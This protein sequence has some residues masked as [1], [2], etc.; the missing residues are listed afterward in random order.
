MKKLVTFGCSITKDNYQDT[1]ADLLAHELGVDLHNHAERGAGADYVS[2]RILTSDIEVDDLVVIMWPSA[3]R[4][5]LWADATTPH[6]LQD[7]VHAS[8]PDGTQPQLVDL[9]GQA[10]LDQGYILNGSVP[11]GYKH[12]YFKYFYSPYQ[13]VHDWYTAIITAQ[14][15]LN[16]RGITY[17][18]LTALPFDCPINYH[19]GT[20]QPESKIVNK[21]DLEK[22]AD[23]SGFLPWA[24][25]TKQPFLNAHYPATLA[26]QKYIDTFLLPFLKNT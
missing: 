24:M 26:H 18:M 7:Y 1:W 16:A 9:H 13:V 19:H 23:T 3:D 4:Y 2:K 25:A 5:D 12:K 11:R 22:F 8:W 20:F 6:L 10:R 21:I 17:C 15:Y 14:L